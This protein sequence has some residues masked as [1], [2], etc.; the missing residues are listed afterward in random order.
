MGLCEPGACSAVGDDEVAVAEQIMLAVQML[1]FHV[2]AE[3]WLPLVLNIV[4]NSG[5]SDAQVLLL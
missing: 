5:T 4:T 3:Y 2:K 1:G